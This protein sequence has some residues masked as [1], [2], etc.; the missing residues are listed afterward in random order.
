VKEKE[1]RTTSKHTLT[2]GFICEFETKEGKSGKNKGL[3]EGRVLGI[4][5]SS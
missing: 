4:Q 1:M 3:W 5:F 2:L